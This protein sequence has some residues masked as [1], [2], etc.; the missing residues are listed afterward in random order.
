[1]NKHYINIFFCFSRSNS[2]TLSHLEEER[3]PTGQ[4]I[5]ESS[6]SF[7][8]KSHLNA[9]N[10]VSQAQIS[11]ESSPQKHCNTSVDLQDVRMSS[12]KSANQLHKSR[13]YPT[14]SQQHNSSV[15]CHESKL[16]E[17][18]ATH[19]LALKFQ[20]IPN[21]RSKVTWV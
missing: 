16:S 2:A 3:F 19:Q 9:N 8:V 5:S 15:K 7:I 21:H 11:T 4:Q 12:F 6:Q 17:T 18:H 13:A 20:D 1:M 14:S 10:Y